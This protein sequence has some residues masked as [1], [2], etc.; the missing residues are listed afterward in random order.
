M[1]NQSK[2]SLTKSEKVKI[3]KENYK[4]KSKPVDFNKLPYI[5]KIYLLA[6]LRV[7]TDEEFNKI[8]P[9][10]SNTKTKNLSPTQSMDESILDCLNSSKIILVDPNSNHNSFNFNHEKCLG[11]KISEVFW[12]INICQNDGERLQLF[13]SY[14]LI[15]D[16]LT[17]FVPTDLSPNLIPQLG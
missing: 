11:F 8:I 5:K 1:K 7:L 10:S 14:R 12:I 3:I 13:E 15:Y 2:K 4:L 9:L 17:K 6:V 16:N